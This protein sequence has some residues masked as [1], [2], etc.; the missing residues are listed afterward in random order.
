MRSPVLPF[1]TIAVR[2]MPAAARVRAWGYDVVRVTPV[3][4]SG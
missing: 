4:T 3:T 1:A 2:P